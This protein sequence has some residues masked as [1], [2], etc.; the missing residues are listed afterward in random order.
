MTAEIAE[1]RQVVQQQA[2]LM[3][4]QVEEEKMSLHAVK[5]L[6]LRRLYKD[7]LFAKVRMEQ[8]LRLNK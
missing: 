7:F 8:V 2:E 5:M 1:L 6:C 4:K 3:H